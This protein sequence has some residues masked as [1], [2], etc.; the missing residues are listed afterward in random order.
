MLYLLLV[1]VIKIKCN[2]KA[3][4]HILTLI[5]SGGRR[6]SSSFNMRRA[7]PSMQCSSQSPSPYLARPT[8]S[9]HS[10]TSSFVHRSTCSDRGPVRFPFISEGR[11]PSKCFLWQGSGRWHKIGPSWST[12][13]SHSCFCTTHSLL[14]LHQAVM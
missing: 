2:A 4:S 5:S 10:R 9:S 13:W 3:F 1:N 7:S 11:F 12:L 14:K 8:S 6:R